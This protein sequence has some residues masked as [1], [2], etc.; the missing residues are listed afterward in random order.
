MRRGGKESRIDEILRTVLLVLL[1][2]S[3][4]T[5]LL[6][7]EAMLSS[8][9]QASDVLGA[10]AALQLLE[11][12]SRRCDAGAAA[13]LSAAAL[14]QLLALSQDGDPMLQAQAL[15]VHTWVS[16]AEWQG[17]GPRVSTL[18][19]YSFIYCHV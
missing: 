17:F 5:G 16:V 7:M 19:H 18:A 13:L 11:D 6:D 3:W 4:V 9:G 10:L 2:S 12:L 15:Q 14:P 1:T 8:L